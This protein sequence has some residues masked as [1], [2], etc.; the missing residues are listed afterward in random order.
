MKWLTYPARAVLCSAVAVFAVSQVAAQVPN[1][2][3]EQREVLAQA[4]EARE[5]GN[6]E[7]AYRDL[8][9]LSE[10]LPDDESVEALLDEVERDLQARGIQPA[11][12]LAGNSEE[13]AAPR[14]EPAPEVE[15]EEVTLAD[16][17]PVNARQLRR[18]LNQLEP[19]EQTRPDLYMEQVE[20]LRERVAAS[21]QADQLVPLIDEYLE[22][23]QFQRVVDRQRDAVA[24]AR[25]A[26]RDAREILGN[27]ERPDRFEQARRILNPAR[28]NLERAAPESRVLADIHD[29]LREIHLHEA[30][31]RLEAGDSSAAWRSFERYTTDPSEDRSVRRLAEDVRTELENPYNVRAAEVSPDW[32]NRRGEVRELL[33]QG[34]AQFV[35][36]DLQGARQTF[37]EVETID[38]SNVE[39]KAFLLEIAERTSRD[40]F[41]D[42]SKT[43]AEMLAQVS[44]AW[45][46]PRVYGE[47]PDLE[48]DTERDRLLER[49][50][51]IVIPRVTFAQSSL[52]GTVNSLSEMSIEFDTTVEDEDRRGINMVVTEPTDVEISF[53]V[54]N[55]SLA[56]ILDIV[57]QQSGYSWDIVGDVVEFSEAAEVD[58]RLQ[59]A[60]IPISRTTLDLI[61]DFQAAAPTRDR[62]RDDP[63]ASPTAA[64]T[65][66]GADERSELLMDFFEASGI[67]FRNIQG[68]SVIHRGN[69]LMVNQTA[70]NIEE[71]RRTLREID[72]VEQVEIEAKF[73]EV[74]QSDLDQLGFQW[75]ISARHRNFGFEG[76]RNVRTFT[77]PRT[78]VTT[79]GSTLDTVFST[80]D[81]GE[82]L[83]IIDRPGG[84]VQSPVTPGSP[85]TALDL[86]EGVGSLFSTVGVIGEYSVDMLINA[87][88]RKQGTDLLSAPKVTVISGKE[89][90]IVV[91]QE[92]I[93]P[94]RYGDPQV[95]T[96]T[97]NAEASAISVTGGVPDDFETRN[98]GVE[99]TV[100]PV[101][102]PN[103]KINLTLDPRVTEFEGFVQYGAPSVAIAGDITVSSPSGYFQPIFATRSVR[104]EVTVFDGATVVLGGLTREE[105]NRFTEKVP[106]LGDVP[107]FGRLF[108]SEG[109]TVQKRNLLIFVT[110]NLISAGG[111]PTAQR[112]EGV[113]PGALFQSPSLVSPGGS[114]QRA[115]QEQVAPGAVAPAGLR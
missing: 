71:I 94:T 46:Q 66:P 25:Q 98:V 100:T 4:L 13:A 87:L 41:W 110:A 106:F 43:R 56:R 23:R 15:P 37:Y 24:S 39:A 59:R 62:G 1:G 103:E 85:P 101:V 108:R 9:R 83:L 76:N 112:F 67:P 36:G 3:R 42:R 111:A 96:P 75:D 84:S 48:V 61:V 65:G 80:G 63:F 53:S 16:D 68:A 7:Q 50:E 114:L 57:A 12:V 31:F 109:E 22:D 73:M 82:N 20:A 44:D 113:Q 21:P 47:D 95:S 90:N 88:S 18:Q 69:R 81:F 8:V 14:A 77:D 28:E 26:R 5:E 17:V 91:A 105:V 70:R 54:R 72:V 30:M 10:A 78:Q 102:E 34:R 55:L 64:P 86:G 104:T 89:A 6:L 40:G 79:P 45:T 2:A 29:D 51:S 58:R 52:T 97:G 60:F 107:L 33:R 93:Y 38:P 27:E 74:V 99:L 92:F 35:N 11:S 32:T 19:L 49:L 115:R